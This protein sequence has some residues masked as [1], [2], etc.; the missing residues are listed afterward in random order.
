MPRYS[1]KLNITYQDTVEVEATSPEE[2]AK[3]AQL[4][5]DHWLHHDQD[6]HPLVDVEG[7]PFQMGEYS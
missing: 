6:V 7:S 3:L 1:V 2:A 5:A 4:G